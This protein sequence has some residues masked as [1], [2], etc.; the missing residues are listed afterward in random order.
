MDYSAVRMGLSKFV[1]KWRCRD[2]KGD[3]RSAEEAHSIEEC[4]NQSC[5]CKI[6]TIY[7]IFLPSE[8]QK[9]YGKSLFDSK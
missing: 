5:E 2:Y 1:Y 9:F 8:I 3:S 4:K 7:K 6:V